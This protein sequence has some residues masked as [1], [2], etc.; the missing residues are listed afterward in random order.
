MKICILIRGIH[1]YDRYNSPLQHIGIKTIDYRQS[2]AN[3]KRNLIGAYKNETVDIYLSTYETKFLNDLINDYKPKDFYVRKFPGIINDI[4][5]RNYEMTEM[6]INGLDLIKEEYDMYIVTRFD[7]LFTN[8]LNTLYPKRGFINVS[9]KTNN[10]NIDDNLHIFFKED[11]KHFRKTMECILNNGGDICARYNES[12]TNRAFLLH[13]LNFFVPYA[14]NRECKTR[15][16][17]RDKICSPHNN[18]IYKINEID[19]VPYEQKFVIIG[20]QNRPYV[21]GTVIRLKN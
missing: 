6:I 12:S 20:K 13:C 16:M 21:K 3:Y 2:V 8:P 1:Y 10:N 18:P 7:L 15:A 9:H 14:T 5:K 17:Y 19:K 11:L 4:V